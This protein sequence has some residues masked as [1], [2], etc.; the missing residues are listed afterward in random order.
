MKMKE[1]ADQIVRELSL[2]EEIR[3][4]AVKNGQV[5]EGIPKEHI[6]DVAYAELFSEVNMEKAT[7]S[8]Y[9]DNHITIFPSQSQLA[10]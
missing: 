5:I 1:Q 9:P 4:F 10:C 2:E 6:L 7:M 3:L 8:V